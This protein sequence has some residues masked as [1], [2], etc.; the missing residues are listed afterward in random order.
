MVDGRIKTFLKLCEVM[1]YRKT[2]ELLHMTQPAVTQHIKFLEKEYGC[3]LFNYDKRVLTMT[4]QA[5]I[6]RDYAENIMYQE[7]KAKSRI[8]EHSGHNLK[9]GATRTIGGYVIKQQLLNYLSDENNIISVEIDNTEHLLE[10]LSKGEI[11]FALIE[12]FFDRKKYAC[13][14]YRREPFIGICGRK[15]PFAGKTVPLE[16]LWQEHL[17]LREEGSGTRDIFQ[18]LLM[19]HNH[20]VSE[21]HRI[22]T[23]SDF[24]LMIGLLLDTQGITFAYRAVLDTSRD[25]KP[26]YIEGFE[27]TRE[28]NY[29]FLNNSFSLGAVKVFDSYR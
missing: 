18:Q 3:R 5:V 8:N 4:E 23:I 27:A 22:T 29:V 19:E 28:F 20:S 12:G 14:L 24:G 11:D 26:F 15:H 16:Q 1:N 6:L 17:F 10:L 9:I 25:L 21:F 2:A 7:Q 13:Q